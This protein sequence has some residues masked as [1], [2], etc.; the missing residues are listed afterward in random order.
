MKSPAAV[1]PARVESDSP[2][3]SGGTLS[4]RWIQSAPFDSCFFLLSP[5]FGLSIILA[6]AFLS[7]HGA[8]LFGFAAFYFVGMPHYLSTYTFYLGDD[9]FAHYWMR[10]AAFF[11][12]PLVILAAVIFLRQMTLGSA[13][14]SAVFTWNIYHVSMQSSGILNIYRKL[15]DGPMSEK[16]LASL[17]ILAVN[18]TMAFWFIERYQ[19]LTLLL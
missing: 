9:N 18:S 11:G 4:C 3:T 14:A 12:G 19:P 10:R 13:L 6:N 16:K 15:N 1:V 5:I 8:T 2:S 17:A 7:S